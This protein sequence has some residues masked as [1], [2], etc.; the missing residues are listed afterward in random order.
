MG[1]CAL[2][3]SGMNSNELMFVVFFVLFVLAIVMMMNI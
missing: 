2:V 3:L 1:V